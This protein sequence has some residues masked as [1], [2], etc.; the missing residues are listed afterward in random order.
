MTVAGNFKKSR[1]TVVGVA[2][3][4]GAGFGMIV[5]TLFDGVSIAIGAGVGAGVGVVFGAAWDAMHFT[6]APAGS[7]V[8]GDAPDH[9]HGKDRAKASA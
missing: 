3:I 7:D 1:S 6:A 4:V 2:L 8:E 9:L 5:G